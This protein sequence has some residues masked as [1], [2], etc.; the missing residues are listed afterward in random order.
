MAEA[1]G[2]FLVADRGALAGV[3]SAHAVDRGVDVVWWPPAGLEA[4]TEALAA[5]FVGVLAALGLGATHG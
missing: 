4:L 5:L 1:P 3:L 2:G